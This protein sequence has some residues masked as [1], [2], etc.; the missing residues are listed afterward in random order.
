MAKVHKFSSPVDLTR[1]SIGSYYANIYNDET[2]VFIEGRHYEMYSGNAM[3][4]EVKELRRLGYRVE[5]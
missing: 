3:M 5:W 4:D 1:E 2:G